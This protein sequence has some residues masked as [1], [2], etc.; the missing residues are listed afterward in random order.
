M[1]NHQLW[2][3]TLNMAQLQGK[4]LAEAL[5]LA[6][7]NQREHWPFKYVNGVQ[8]AKSESLELDKKAHKSTPFD[9]EQC[10]DALL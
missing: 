3:D 2:L 9:L 10:E 1:T 7:S 6:D 8:T 5:T 4:P